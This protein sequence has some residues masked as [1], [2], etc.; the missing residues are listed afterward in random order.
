MG[1]L[2]G[3]VVALT[4]GTADFLGGLSSRRL[5]VPVVLVVGQFTGL[6]LVAALVATTGGNDVSGTAVI[7]GAAAG[8]A[9]FVG[10]SL[11]FQGLAGGAMAVIAPIAAVGSA[12]VPFVWAVTISGERPGAAATA[13]VVAAVIGVAIVARP[14]S[15]GGPRPRPVDL[16]RATASGGAFGLIFVL[17]GDAGDD[18]GLIPVLAS[19]AVSFPLAVISLGVYTA[20]TGWRPR[21]GSVSGRPGATAALL[22]AQGVFDSTANSVFIAAA[23]SGLLSEVSVVSALYPAPTVVLAAVVLHERVSRVQRAGL[24]LVLA[25]VALIAL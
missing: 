24:G 6:L 2:L 19:R 18:S 11:F 4:Y 22:V 5:P 1:V 16:A 10:L 13:G 3:A 15:G 17:L 7:H 8:V 23:H 9:G 25:G 14:A 20:R 12:V 21:A